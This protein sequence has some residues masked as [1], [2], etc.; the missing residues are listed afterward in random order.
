MVKA[1][2]D[3]RKTQT[4]RTFKARRNSIFTPGQWADSY[5]L[6]PG[7]AEWRARETPW[8][9]GDV[10]WVREAFTLV[11]NVDPPWVLYRASGYEAEC[12]RHGFDNPPPETSVRWKPSIHMPRWASRIT[13]KVTA[14]KVER[15]QD[16]SEDDAKA[17]G[18]V[19]P[20][21]PHW[22]TRPLASEFRGI[23]HDIHGA[24]AWDANPWVVA[25][26]FVRNT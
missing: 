26:T 11:G 10:L 6:D 12:K 17:E 14:V 4:R 25:V 1:I 23:W 15:L 22:P 19:R 13:L 5:V 8:A 21:F 18:M 16:I 9:V 2:L 24:G 20:I 3:G 7:N